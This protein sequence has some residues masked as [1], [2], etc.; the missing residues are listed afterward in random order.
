MRFFLNRKNFSIIIFL[1]LSTGLNAQ[2][3]IGTPKPL[4]TLDINGDLFV[5]KELK[6]GGTDTTN[7]DPGLVGQVLVSQGNNFSPA[8][9]GVSVPFM[10]D[11]QYRLVNTYLKSDQAGIAAANFSSSVLSPETSVVGETL[12]AS[13]NKIAGLSF[14]LEI[15]NANNNITYQLQTGAEI[16]NTSSSGAGQSTRYICGIFK[17]NVLAALRPD[18]LITIDNSTPMQGIYTLNYNEINIP[19]GNYTID[20]ACRKVYTSNS[21]NSMSIGVN[22]SNANNQSNAFLLRSI[23]KVDVAELV[24]YSN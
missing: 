6:V 16:Q 23:L 7:G 19:V 24:I 1:Q 18:G 9:K 2:V 13:W 14:N 21:N 4:S 11:K 15:K 8:W 12:S 3:G 20:V 17:N 22:I 10:E 5:R